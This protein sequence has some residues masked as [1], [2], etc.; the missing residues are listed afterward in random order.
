[1]ERH[2]MFRDWKTQH[3]KDV[4]SPQIIYKFNIIHIKVLENLSCCKIYMERYKP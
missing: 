2:S 1:M 4:N 3:S